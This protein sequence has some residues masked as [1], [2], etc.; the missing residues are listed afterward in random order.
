M[1]VLDWFL[2]EAFRMSAVHAAQEFVVRHPEVAAT[3]EL[4]K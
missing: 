4:T 1:I 3:L 2:H